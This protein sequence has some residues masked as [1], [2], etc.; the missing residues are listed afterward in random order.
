VLRIR[1][2]LLFD[3]SIRDPGQGS[4]LAKNADP[5]S[6]IRDR[7]LFI[8]VIAF[9]L[10]ILGFYFIEGLQTVGTVFLSVAQLCKQFFWAGSTFFH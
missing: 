5:G 8:K 4:G 10:E 3:P 9:G 1:D 7:V 6:E 2:L